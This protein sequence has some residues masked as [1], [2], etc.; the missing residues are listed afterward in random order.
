MER[1]VTDS[2]SAADGQSPADHHLES[3]LASGGEKSPVKFPVEPVRVERPQC[4]ATASDELP[5]RKPLYSHSRSM[6]LAGAGHRGKRLSLSFPVQVQPFGATSS[7]ESPSSSASQTPMTPA[8]PSAT[9]RDAI[10]LPVGDSVGFLV[11]LAAH[12]RRVL[13]LREELGRAEGEL[14]RLKRQWA[15][16]EATKKRGEVRAVQPLK[17]MSNNLS[18]PGG[19]GVLS[20]EEIE[21]IELWNVEQKRRR[22]IVTGSLANGGLKTLASSHRKV[23]SGQRHTRTLSLLSPDRMK[24]GQPFPQPANL[25][26]ELREGPLEDKPTLSPSMTLPSAKPSVAP[27]TSSDSSQGNG[28]STARTRNSYHG[29]PREALI[30][31][32]RQ[33]AEDFKEGLWT[34]IEDLRQATVG[35]EGVNATASRTATSP[36]LSSTP[37]GAKKK[38]SKGSLRGNGR[39]PNGQITSS[40]NVASSSEPLKKGGKGGL[41]GAKDSFWK[42]HG[43]QTPRST[44]GRQKNTPNK[45]GPTLQLAE[46]HKGAND[47]DDSWENWDSPDTKL[48]PSPRW[49]S[50]TFAHSDSEGPTSTDGKADTS[51]TDASATN[52]SWPSL[53]DLSPGNLKRTASTL[54]KELERQGLAPPPLE[55]VVQLGLSGGP[56]PFLTGAEEGRKAD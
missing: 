16:H 37:K 53:S 56:K 20:K 24:Y 40:S 21:N 7:R 10:P 27:K 32:G 13:E 12:E 17:S 1:E 29:P 44:T 42:E 45:T 9:D 46:E 41:S 33:M 48:P 31:T 50:S 43:V 4:P 15:L 38:G 6:S 51:L 2:A 55:R 36:G 25:N 35:D 26:A 11:A 22:A 54:I 14:E 5:V 23:I 18:G 3:T 49:S 34:F 19:D 47:D 52:I 28:D 39:S 30:R 8:F